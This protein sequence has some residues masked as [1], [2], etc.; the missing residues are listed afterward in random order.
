NGGVAGPIRD[1]EPK[2]V[3]DMQAHD[4]SIARLRRVMTDHVGVVRD[5]TG[6]AHAIDVISGIGAD[7]V[8]QGDAALANMAL[9]ARLVATCA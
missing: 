9:T 8:A 6:L 7:A 3:G 2:P 5:A 4:A 1:Y